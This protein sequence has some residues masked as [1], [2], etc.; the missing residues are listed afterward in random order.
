ML[1]KELAGQTYVKSDVVLA[2]Q[3]QVNR[4]SKAIQLK[5]CNISAVLRDMGQPWVP[6]FKP[7]E[8]VQGRLR[9]LITE[10][11]G[12]LNESGANG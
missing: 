6:G 4:S 2:T 7:L 8:N 10:R 3:R 11:G 12:R 1:D 5:F 9:E